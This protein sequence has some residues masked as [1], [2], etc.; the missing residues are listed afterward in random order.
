MGFLVDHLPRRASGR[1]RPLL[2]FG[3]VLCALNFLLLWFG[4]FLAPVGKLAIA[5]LSYVLI[6]LTFDLMDIPLNSLI[7]VMTDDPRERNVLSSLKGFA[8]LSCSMLVVV[9]APLVVSAAKVPVR[10]YLFLVAAGAVVVVV[11]SLV[12]AAGVR[13]RIVP[14]GAEQRYRLRQLLPML[15]LAPVLATFLAQL[16]YSIG[17][18]MMN[19]TLIYFVTYVLDHRIEVLSFAGMASFGGMLASLAL[20]ARLATKRGKKVVFGAGLLLF[21]GGLL[22]RGVLVA[23][24]PWLYA[25]SA[26]TGLGVGLAMPLVY[27]IQADNVDYVDWKM[28][29]RA[30]GSLAAL[31]SFII[32]AAAGL[33]GAIPGYLLAA[34]GYVANQEQTQAARDAIVLASIA[35]PAVLGLAAGVL[36]LVLY[37]LDGPRMKEIEAG[38]ARRRAG[39][40]DAGG[41]A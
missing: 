20:S 33:G 31:L 3:A 26:V 22:L 16:L 36:F 6:G 29:F 11:G 34:A 18:A 30:E 7:P 13:E 4:P 39:E 17:T 40:P 38:L 10:A 21:G 35:L 1:F 23:S 19:A 9:G 41:A 25:C 14:V 8:Y 27:G 37:P 15:L 32:K 28:G 5:Y 12:G 2:G 24:I